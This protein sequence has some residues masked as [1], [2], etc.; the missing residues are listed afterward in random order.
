MKKMLASPRNAAMNLLARREH[1][2]T[3][4]ERKLRSRFSPQELD[5]AL[6][7][8]VDEQLQSDERFAMSFTR[9][10]MRRGHG[11]LR[12]SAELTQRG[13]DSVLA[14][15]AIAAIPRDEGVSWQSVAAEALAKK[16]G[17]APAQD[18]QEKARRIRFLRYRGF[19]SEHG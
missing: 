17:Y 6:Q 9:E 11:P 12:I 7:R 15:R 18:I 5:E 2:R 19:S 8:L 14:D 1:S 13:V 3:E 4:L 10:R 16:F